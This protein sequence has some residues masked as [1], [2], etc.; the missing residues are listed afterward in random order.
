MKMPPPAG[1]HGKVNEQYRIPRPARLREVPSYLR[2]LFGSF[3]SRLLYIFRL[4]YDTKKSMLLFMVVMAV[5]NGV[6]PVLNAYIAANLLDMLARAL[7]HQ[8]GHFSEIVYL[9]LAQAGMLILQ[10]AVTQLYQTEL[11][12]CGELVTNHI[13]EMIMQKSKEVDIASFDQ[14]E[15]Y[16]KLDN[17]NREARSEPLDIMRSSFSIFS[18]LISM[19]SFIVILQQIGWWAAPLI[20]VCAIPSAVVRHIYARKNVNYMFFHSRHR[21]EMNYFSN[22]LVDKDHVKEIRLFGTADVLI[23]KYRNV[24]SRYFAGMK[25][26]VTQGAAWSVGFTVLSSL[27]NGALLVY[28][29]YRVYSGEF[30]VGNYSLI[31]GA[32]SSISSGMVT[33]ITTATSIYEGTLFINN[34]I[35]YMAEKPHVLPSTDAPLSPARHCGHTIEVRNVSFRYPGGTRDVLSHVDLTIHA[36]ETVVLV[37]LN[38]A[39]KTTLIK[40]ITRLYD[41]TEGEILLDGKNIKEYELSELYSL[42]GIIFQ[43]FG[44]YALTA[45]ENVKFGEISRTDADDEIRAAAERADVAGY[46]EKLPNGYETQLTKWFDDEGTELSGGQWQKLAV[47]RAFFRSSDILILDEPTSALDA[48]AEQ[49][50][51]RQFD[52]LR[53][54]KTTVFVSHRLSSATTADRIIV[55]QNGQVLETGSHEELMRRDGLYREMFTT[56]AS[57]YVENMHGEPEPPSGGA[58]GQKAGRAEAQPEGDE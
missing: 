45:G 40:L 43:D 53:K 35:S 51:Y 25:K 42:F 21:R 41:P 11:R 50:I 32:I 56:Q 58:P 14:P 18:T 6:F 17:A 2:K 27:I 48:L 34:L 54:N 23:D 9:L 29:A 22:V 26:L 5:L 24:F 15:F 20:V 36:G 49:E 39:G 47:A 12:L 57:R 10:N 38:G 33:L 13:K 1:R 3:F 31:A 52:M 4:V 46:I 37:G 8:V 19:V 30:T 44:R 16:A 7:M 28:L 55:L